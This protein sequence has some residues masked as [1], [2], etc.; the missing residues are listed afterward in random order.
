MAIA[1]L[2]E[3]N[4]RRSPGSSAPTLRLVAGGR[5]A[6]A[7]ARRTAIH[8]APDVR[9][10]PRRSRDAHPSAQRRGGGATARDDAPTLGQVAQS[11]PRIRAAAVSAKT[12]RRRAGGAAV[13]LLAIALLSMPVHAFGGVTLAGQSTPGAVPAGVAPGSV[14]VVQAGDTI[15]SLAARIN[16]NAVAQIARQI[17]AEVG[18]RT[19]VPGERVVAP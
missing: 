19:L 17:A 14:I 11:A 16:P 8:A 2:E 9:E 1:P 4:K 3:A 10:V 13:A 5:P 12:R 6:T 7:P 18:S 15:R